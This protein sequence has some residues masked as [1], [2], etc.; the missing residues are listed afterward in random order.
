MSSLEKTFGKKIENIEYFERQCAYAIGFN[1]KMQIPVI[2]ASTGYFLLGGGI[3][4]EETHEECI[5]RECLEEAGLSVN[6]GKFICKGANY[7][8]SPTNKCHF[9]AIG[10]FY[11]IT[12]GDFVCNPTEDD[13]ELLW[14]SV[15]ECEQKLF[16]EHQ[17]WAVKQ[18]CNFCDK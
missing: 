5:K 6:V 1:E 16:L 18:A 12:I 2:K 4:N 3:E 15:E 17:S 10:Y 11:F 14:L 8:L 7:F 13:G 9:H